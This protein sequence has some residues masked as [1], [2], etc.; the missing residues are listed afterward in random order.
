VRAVDIRSVPTR[1]IA[2]PAAGGSHGL[3]LGVVL[4]TLSQAVVLYGAF[5]NMRGIFAVVT[6]HDLRVA[7]DGVDIEQIATVFE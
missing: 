2:L 1:A 5:E 3:F 7:E 4:G 6:Y